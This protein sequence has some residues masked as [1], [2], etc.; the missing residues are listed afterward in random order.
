LIVG[1]SLDELTAGPLTAFGAVGFALYAL[2]SS[3]YSVVVAVAYFY[4][5]M[6][7]EGAG[8]EDIVTVFD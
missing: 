3:F 4:L 1:S 2:I 5:R 6:E 7:K 8:V